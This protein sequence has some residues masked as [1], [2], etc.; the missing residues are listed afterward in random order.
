M[1]TNPYAPEKE[2]DKWLWAERLLL[3]QM[4]PEEFTAWYKD[5][6]IRRGKRY[7]FTYDFAREFH[8]YNAYQIDAIFKKND[9]LPPGT[10]DDNEMGCITY[11]FDSYNFAVQFCEDL[12]EFMIKRR[13]VAENFGLH[14]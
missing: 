14:M 3:G 7:E 5:V 4:T 12:A 10:T 1:N 13:E 6:L 11:F 8:G 2:Y 9:I